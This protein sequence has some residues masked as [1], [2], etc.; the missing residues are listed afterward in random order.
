M[1]DTETPEPLVKDAGGPQLGPEPPA[2]VALAPLAPLVIQPPTFGSFAQD[3]GASLCLLVA[4]LAKAQG[5]FTEIVKNRTANIRPRDSSKSPYSFQYADL[6]A[7]RAAITPALSANGLALIAFPEMVGDVRHLTVQ[8][9]HASGGYIRASLPLPGVSEGQL[10]ETIKAFGGLMTYLR[11]YLEVALLNLSAD[12]D[13]DE[14]PEG[15]ADFTTGEVAEHPSLKAAKS[16]GE[17]S[18][19]M[20]ALNATDKRKYAAYF[21]QRQKELQAP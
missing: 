15:A 2:T 12:N 1:A 21:N 20:T 4:A 6:D 13:L 19:A 5:E 8:L 17:L 9:M 14:D 7:I 10:T 3:V 18:R 16:I 11:R